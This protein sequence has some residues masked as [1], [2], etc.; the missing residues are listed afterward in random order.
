[1]KAT[2]VSLRFTHMQ[3]D[4]KSV[5]QPIFVIVNTQLLP[6]KNS[7]KFGSNIVIFKICPKGENSPNL[8]TLPPRDSGVGRFGDEKGKDRLWQQLF[9]MSARFF[10]A[11]RT[12]TGGK[13]ST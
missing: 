1:M 5:S 8:V 7:L 6:W 12:K 10:S 4:P 2:L 11:Q 9:H 3:D 13:Y